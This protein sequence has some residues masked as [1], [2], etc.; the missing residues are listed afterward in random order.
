MPHYFKTHLIICILVLMPFLAFAD[1]EIKVTSKTADSMDWK[2][3]ASGISI[4]PLW[5]DE[6]TKDT[7]FLMKFVAGFVGIDHGHT[8]AYQGIT[9]QGT[10]VHIDTDGTKHTLPKGS[11]AHQPAKTIH[12]D[13]CISKK[14]CIIFIHMDG[15][16]DFFLAKK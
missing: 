12:S 11:F 2:E 9:V 8:N 3:L 7:G 13:Q 5:K 4:T 10:W 1:E 16:Y 6:K 15:D 14:P